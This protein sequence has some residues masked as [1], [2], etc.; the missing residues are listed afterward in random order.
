MT[1][2]IIFNR[3]AERL[4]IEYDNIFVSSEYVAVPPSFPAVSIE[5]SDSYPEKNGI[6][7]GFDDEQERFM[8]TVN[9]YSDLAEG[10]TE[11]VKSIM[12]TVTAE[13]KQMYFTKTTQIPVPNAQDRSIYRETARYTRIIGGGENLE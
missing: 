5:I 9:A 11:Q 8:I 10:K 4:L 3:I 7:L 12:K 6:T 2:T 1:E 13:M